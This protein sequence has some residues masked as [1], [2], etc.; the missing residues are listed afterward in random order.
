MTASNICAVIVSF[1]P[2]EAM[3]ANLASIRAQAHGL[4]VVDNGSDGESLARL[5]LASQGFGFQLVENGENV[6][7]AE[8]LNR[9]VRLAISKGFPWVILLDQ[10]S[11]LTDGFVANMFAAW[12]LHPSRK[13]V[14][15]MHPTYRNPE[16]GVVPVVLRAEDG[17]PVASIT[18]GALMP[19]WIFEKAG[20][21]SSDFFIDWVDIEY[22]L[23]IRAAGYLVAD[24]AEAVLLHTA[25]HPRRTSFLGFNFQ[26][27][28]HSAERRYYISRNRIVVFRRYWR[29]FPRWIASLTYEAFRETVKCFLAEENRPRKF[30]N[31]LFGTWDGLTGRMG[32]REGL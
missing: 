5:R 7:I 22:C 27:S 8:A 21:F 2:T 9:G 10:D 32:R 24:T 18:S 19:A 14:G 17:G 4:V 28:H 25:G 20:W 1:G 13:R 29:V 23:R 15:S 12:E 11:Q 31:F 30:R 3:V 16:T 6:G 26:P